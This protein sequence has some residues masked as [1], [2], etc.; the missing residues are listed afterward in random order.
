MYYGFLAKFVFSVAYLFDNASVQT[1]STLI[2][3]YCCELTYFCGS[4]T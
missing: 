1:K 4:E 3:L 2:C